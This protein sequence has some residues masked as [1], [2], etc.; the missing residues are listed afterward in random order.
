[1]KTTLAGRFERLPVWLHRY[2]WYIVPFY[3]ALIV[4]A[5]VGAGREWRDDSLKAWFGTDSQIY[6]DITRFERLFGSNEDLYIVYEARDGAI[7]SEPSLS[8]LKRLHDKLAN[9]PVE[10]QRD[11]DSALKHVREVLSLINLPVTKVDGDILNMEPFIG[12][13]LPETADA[14]VRLRADALQDQDLRLRFVSP[15]ARFGG[16]M[17]KTNFGVLPPTYAS[18]EID[19]QALIDFSFEE[20]AAENEMT[21]DSTPAVKPMDYEEYAAFVAE[22]RRMVHDAGVGEDLRVHFIGLPEIIAFNTEVVGA[23]MGQI[24][25]GLFVLMFALIYLVFRHLSAVAWSLSLILITVILTLGTIGWLNVPTSS[26]TDAMKLMVIL[27]ST[28]DAIHIISSYR[29]HRQQGHAYA[30]AIARAYARA[31][32]A[33]FLTSLTTV[34]GFASLWVVKPSEP[35][36]N[37]GLFAALGITYAFVATITLMPIMLSWWAPE[38]KPG[39][40]RADGA[41]KLQ[42]VIFDL[43]YRL[44]SRSPAT[45][46]AAFAGFTLVLGAGMFRLEVDTNTLEA[47]DETTEIRQAFEVADQHMGGTQNI[48]FMIEMGRI[49]AIYDP[50]VLRRIDRLQ[51]EMHA[52]FP[53]LIVTSQSIVDVLKRIN[54]QFNGDDPGYYRLPESDGKTGQLLFLFNN[55]SP[56]ERRRLVADDFDATRISFTV[57]NAGS[58]DFVEL[59]SQARVLGDRRF[60]E[61]RSSYPDLRVTSSGGVVSFMHLYDKIASSQVLSFAITLAI[62]SAVLLFVFGSV[63]LGILALIPN[64]IPIVVTF[65]T[66]GWLGISLSPTTMILAPIILGIAVDDSIHIINKLKQTMPSCANVGEAVR[67]TLNEAGSAICFTSLIL[68]GGLLTMLYSSDAN[69]QAFGYL[70]ALAIGSA[71][72]ADLLLIPSMLLVTSQRGLTV[73]PRMLHEGGPKI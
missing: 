73:L 4:L 8:A 72:L 66:M 49:D 45:M 50:Q 19:E 23:E 31:G 11:A 59:V 36:A 27:I 34:I 55:V 35:I 32:T 24:F 38:T 10:I 67:H 30:D 56:D 41:R 63:R 25:L 7:F 44:V 37:F 17:V 54:R 40:A 57:R 71:L 68:V 13:R 47:F 70:S 42:R 14:R 16:I 69:M 48:D 60:E 39:D 12:N 15:D 20:P 65:G 43:V 52:E 9:F 3:I 58:K 64:I 28:A 29:Y 33:C 46:I 22:V 53:E 18:D 62:V 2:R 6:Q 61:L 5:S 1:M 21:G 51:Q 26:L